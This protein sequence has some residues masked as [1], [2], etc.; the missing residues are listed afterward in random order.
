[1]RREIQIALEEL[2]H[3]RDGDSIVPYWNGTQYKNYK[4]EPLKWQFLKTLWLLFPGMFASPSRFLSPTAA[5]CIDKPPL[6]QAAEATV[7]WLGHSTVYIHNWAGLNIL[8]DPTRGDIKPSPDSKITLYKRHTKPP[9]HFS[10]L[11]IDIIFLSHNHEDHAETAVLIELAKRDPQPL[12]IAGEKSSAWL[13]SLGFKA[14]NIKTMTWWDQLRIINRNAGTTLDL[15]SVPA[16]HGSQPKKWVNQDGSVTNSPMNGMLW[17]G[18]MLRAI[19]EAGKPAATAYFTGDTALGEKMEDAQGTKHELFKQVHQKF[20]QIDLAFMEISPNGEDEVH[21]GDNF[22]NVL[23]EINPKSCIPVHHSC[24]RSDKRTVEAPLEA[25]IAKTFELYQKGEL[26]TA[27]VPMKI[28]GQLFL[29]RLVEGDPVRI[30]QQL[31]E[32]ER[33]LAFGI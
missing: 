31:P 14:E 24:F 18:F 11:A 17:L 29:Q 22:F 30:Q 20:P 5:L 12:V 9:F 25:L 13:Q 4:D 27:I 15:T 28:G 26:A 7:S 33:R 8:F 23:K 6:P 2:A 16:C 32:N 10:D 1:M 21:L 3:L 19:Y